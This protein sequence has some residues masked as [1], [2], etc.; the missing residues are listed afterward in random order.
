MLPFF[1]RIDD[2][3]SRLIA[4]TAVVALLVAACG[5]KPATTDSTTLGS[6]VSNTSSESTAAVSTDLTEATTAETANSTTPAAT[7]DTTALTT[8][9]TV[10]ATTTT[11]VAAA[12]AANAPAGSVIITAEDGVYYVTTEGANKLISYFSAPAVAADLIDFA[13]GDTRGGVIIHPDRGPFFYRGSASIVFWIPQGGSAAQQLL[14]PAVDQGLQLEDVVVQGNSVGVYYTRLEG[15]LPDD[16]LQTLRR[17]DLDTKAVSPIADVAGWESGT[18]NFSVGG[19]LIV[20]EWAGEAYYGFGFRE[21]DGALFDWTLDPTAGALFDCYPE[22]PDAISVSPGGHRFAYAQR[23]A[24]VHWVTIIDVESG[25]TV[26]YFS[27]P[28]GVYEIHSID[29]GND[30][31]VVNRVEEGNEWYIHPLLIE[32]DLASLGVSEIPFNGLARLANVVPQ[33][34]GV[35]LFP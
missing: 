19:D 22:C 18:W 29:L 31:M 5:S 26:A 2:R 10:A 33:L 35:V 4:L 7:T 24:G 3:F 11:T 1:K 17:F 30:Y 25:D 12:E 32:I 14:V 21:L 8:T 20:N 15:S 27:L 13:I 23:T 6:D 16:M 28:G 9:T 34:N